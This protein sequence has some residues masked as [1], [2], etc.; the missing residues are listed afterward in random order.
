MKKLIFVI[1]AALWLSACIEQP[2][3]FSQE[4]E[5]LGEMS[6]SEIKAEFRRLGELPGAP[7][8]MAVGS[9]E[10]KAGLIALQNIDGLSKA[11]QDLAHALAWAGK[12]F[13]RD[14]T[15]PCNTT[16]ENSTF[17]LENR[18]VGAFKY[19]EKL[20]GGGVGTVYYDADSWIDD[21]Y[22][23]I[24]V[25]YSE[26]TPSMG[27]MRNEMRI[28]DQDNGVAGTVTYLGMMWVKMGAA[29]V[30]FAYFIPDQVETYSCI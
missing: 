1:T 29:K 28:S 11:Q 21:G 7:G 3:D 5:R 6:V 27:F 12:D 24:A 30:P 19:I 2:F 18:F 22:P 16:H 8:P 13:Y 23:V 25:D 9:A 26:I 10:V 15:L 14:E 4:A 20:E 17:W